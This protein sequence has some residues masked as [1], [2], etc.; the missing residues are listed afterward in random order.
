MPVCEGQHNGPCPS[1]KNDTS[2]VI[3][4]GDLLLCSSCDSERR[5]RFDE[6]SKLREKEKKTS[7]RNGSSSKSTASKAE[8]SEPSRGGN[9]RKPQATAP[10]AS[11]SSSD[12]QPSQ[13]TSVTS[14]PTN[15][16]GRPPGVK[17]IIN[18]LLTYVSYYR[19]RFTSSDLHTLVV[20]FYSS[21]EISAAKSTVLSQFEVH[22]TSCQYATNRRHTTTT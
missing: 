22:L 6:E 9:S 15:D 16:P 2:V 7:G 3:G 5:R 10:V 19:D 8:N 17:T 14:A 11:T 13:V 1:K 12:S 21:L 4:K 18:K 20:R